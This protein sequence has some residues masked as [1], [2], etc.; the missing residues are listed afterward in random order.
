MRSKV[1]RAEQALR[2]ADKRRASDSGKTDARLREAEHALQSERKAYKIL[3]LQY[4]G[5][6]ESTRVNSRP[7]KKSPCAVKGRAG[8]G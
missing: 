3:Q 4:Q 2:E 6:L 5:L 8:E 1:E 7:L